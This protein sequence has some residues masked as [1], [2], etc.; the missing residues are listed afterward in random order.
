MELHAFVVVGCTPSNHLVV[1][2]IDAVVDADLTLLLSFL[3][4]MAPT[5]KMKKGN[6]DPDKIHCRIQLLV[7]ETQ[8]EEYAKERAC[9]FS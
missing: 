8:R 1:D 6:V 7:R 3:L 4:S 2:A 5:T 9:G